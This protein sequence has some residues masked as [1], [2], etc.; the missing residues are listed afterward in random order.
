V[1]FEMYQK[2]IKQ[3]AFRI[4]L[5]SYDQWQYVDDNR[6][7]AAAQSLILESHWQFPQWLFLRLKSPEQTFFILLRRSIIGPEHFSRLV[8]AIKYQQ[9]ETQQ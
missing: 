2:L 9:H 5:K 7:D 6:Q 8:T 4:A 1:I 3:A